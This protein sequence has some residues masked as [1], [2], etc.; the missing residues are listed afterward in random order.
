[1]RCPTCKREFPPGA[2]QCPQ[3]GTFL[4]APLS[5]ALKRGP[6]AL[7]EA[8]RIGERLCELLEPVHAAGRAHL[9]LTPDNV[10]YRHV[11]HDLTIR[12]T[13]PEETRP[14]PGAR[15]ATPERARGE[16]EDARSDIYLLGVLLHH[17]VAGAPPFDSGTEAV[18]L[19]KHAD[20][21]PGALTGLEL[22]DVPDELD[23][24]IKGMLAKQPSARPQ[25]VRDIRETLENVDTGSTITGAKIASLGVVPAPPSSPPKSVLQTVLD[26]PTVETRPVYDVHD[27]RDSQNPTLFNVEKKPGPDDGGDHPTSLEIDPY[28]DT[29]LRIRP[30]IG[31]A[32]AAVDDGNADT[33]LQITPRVDAPRIT[34]DTE[35]PRAAM[36]PAPSSEPKVAPRGPTLR[37][38]TP[39]DQ[40][41][42]LALMILIGA[43]VVVIGVLAV[44]L[45]TR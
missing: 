33:R 43:L 17:M 8:T 22:Q 13:E 27:A 31:L 21:P 12:I 45:F 30:A 5:E 38:E 16:R 35:P 11:G 19:K 32:G 37:T 29:V 7:A 39:A 10:Y 1:M 4:L 20:T 40:Q 25:S 14:L 36:K 3:D 23:A 6:L 24:L 18:I 42:R 28:G 26:E 41:A 2:L 34:L 15:Y 9:R 44:V